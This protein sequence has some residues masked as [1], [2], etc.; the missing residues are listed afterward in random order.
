MLKYQG[1]ANESPEFAGVAELA[2]AEDLKSCE[3][4]LIPVQVRSPALIRHL[5]L[6]VVNAFLDKS[7]CIL[8]ICV[9]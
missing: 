9:N 7:S 1:S 6:D 2:D 4:K 5:S 3:V 8:G